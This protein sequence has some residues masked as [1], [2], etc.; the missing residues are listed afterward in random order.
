[1]RFF[2]VEVK[3]DNGFH[4]TYYVEAD[5][6]ISQEEMRDY[7]AKVAV[8][9]VLLSDD[10]ETEELE[11]LDPKELTKEDILNIV[12]D[13]RVRAK[14][15]IAA[16]NNLDNV[17]L[18]IYHREKDYSVDKSEFF[19]FSAAAGQDADVTSIGKTDAER[20]REQVIHDGWFDCIAQLKRYWQI[21]GVVIATGLFTI[22]TTC[23][24]EYE[25]ERSERELVL[26]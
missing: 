16:L 3:A 7:V 23:E 11:V 10:D 2:Q 20:S 17:V 12:A 9:D 22:Q 4:D 15:I 19:I 6:L 1:M 18:G 21:P 13:I 14:L 25:L 24:E 5:N 26:V 8:V